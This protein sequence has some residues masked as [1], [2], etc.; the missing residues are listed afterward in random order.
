M[1]RVDCAPIVGTA[2]RAAMVA[3]KGRTERLMGV[4]LGRPHRDR[5]DGRRLATST[6]SAALECEANGARVTP[7]RQS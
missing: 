6:A 2:E 3:A 5:D 1:I 4:G 7:V